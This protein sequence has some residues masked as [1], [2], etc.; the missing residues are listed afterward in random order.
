MKLFAIIIA[1]ILLSNP[2]S[3]SQST[4]FNCAGYSICNY[5]GYNSTVTGP[6]GRPAKGYSNRSAIAWA[7]RFLRGKIYFDLDAGY[8]DPEWD[9]VRQVI[10]DQ[11]GSGYTTPPTASSSPPFCLVYPV[12]GT[13]TLAGNAVSSVP[14]TTPGV[15]CNGGVA[16]TFSG[17]GGSGAHAYAVLG[18]TGTFGVPGETTAGTI[19]RISDITGAGA[20]N[21]VLE[22]G[23]N[24]RGSLTVAD[25]KVNLPSLWSSMTS[26]GQTVWDKIEGPINTS[27]G[28]FSANQYKEVLQTNTWR[29]AQEVDGKIT[30]DSTAEETD[31]ASAAGASLPNMRD[32]F[33]VHPTVLASIIDGHKLENQIKPLLGVWTPEGITSNQLDIYDATRNPLG[34]LNTNPFMATASGGTNSTSCTGTVAGGWVFERTVGSATGIC[35]LAVSTRTDLYSGKQQVFTASL[36][37]GTTTEFYS[38]YTENSPAGYGVSAGDVI[39]GFCDVE[40]SNTKNLNWLELDVVP[41]TAGFATVFDLFDGDGALNNDHYPNGGSL[42]ALSS[43]TPMTWRTPP[44]S[45]PSGGTFTSI[46]D[47]RVVFRIGFDASGGATSAGGTFKITNCGIRKYQ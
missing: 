16:I 10:V 45:M 26:S 44:Y 33:G 24:D 40:A 13:V 46:A 42:G 47:L 15:G 11:G 8:I 4:R 39:Q 20:I 18:G 28:L 29:K 25:T 38:F 19:A 6:N 7:S 22:D 21:M 27:G 35:S 34:I 23:A 17:G 43:S 5:Q 30:L 32:S 14:I 36:G 9:G 37:S 12:F 2:S 41:F 1:I 31:A 3:A